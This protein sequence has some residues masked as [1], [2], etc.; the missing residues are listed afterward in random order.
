MKNSQKSTGVLN[1]GFLPLRPKS[2]A[3]GCSAPGCSACGREGGF[4][5]ISLLFVIIVIGLILASTGQMWSTIVKREKEA[6]LIFRGSEI[7]KAIGS[8]YKRPGVLKV[9]PK[10][11]KVLVEDKRLTTAMRHLR[12]IYVDPMTGESDWELI[13][14]PD[15]GIQGVKSRSEEEPYKKQNFPEELK[16]LEGKLTYNEWEFV[17]V[18][19]KVAT[20]GKRGPA[21]EPGKK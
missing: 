3:P 4:T 9:Y 12:K 8:Y 5:Y 18:Q 10:D 15:G 7:R 20:K 11:L 16:D 17:Y 19:K 21:K 14:A 2:S 13:K 1:H 6:E